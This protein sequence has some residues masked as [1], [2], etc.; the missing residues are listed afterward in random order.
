MLITGATGFLGS[1]VA[2]AFVAAGY[3]VRLTVR[4]NSPRDNLADL[5]AE[6]VVADLADA[7]SLRAALEGCDGLVHVAAD[8]RLFVPD[9]A[10]MYHINVEGTR[11]LMKAALNAG[12]RRIVYT[13]SVATLGHRTDESPANETTPSTQDDMIGHYKRSKFLAEA[14]V[15][16][17]VAE[18]GLPAVIVNPSAPVGPRDIKPTPT[19]SMVFDAARGHMPAYLDTGLNIVHVDDAAAGHLAAYERGRVGERYILGGDNLPLREILGQIAQLAGRRAPRLR[20][21]PG[22]L[23]PLAWCAEAWARATGTRPFFTRD[24]LAMAR[25]P[26]YYSS[27]K[28]EKELGYTHRPATQAFAD[29]LLWFG[30]HRGLALPVDGLQLDTEERHK[31]QA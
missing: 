23:V 30:E 14:A 31:E 6:T 11:E 16:Q 25:H 15:R 28:A 1:A 18:D 13:S 22:P 12:V 10:P 7:P 19:G 2:R 21:A 5:E 27:L 9:P 4:A 29:A 26:M 17:L 24:E 20:L 3:Q 8:Y